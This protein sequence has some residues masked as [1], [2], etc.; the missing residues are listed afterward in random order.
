M[1]TKLLL[2]LTFTLFTIQMM[3]TNPIQKELDGISWDIE[4]T[5][6]PNPNS[7]VFQLN[8]QAD[9]P[10]TYEVKIVNL[11]GKTIVKKEVK[12][13]FETRFDLSTYPKGVYFMQIKSG[14]KQ[15]IKRVVIQ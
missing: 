8:I 10:T 2:L 7:G 1:K 12:T 9:I 5:V 6:Y 14:K 11:I 15:I 3:A 13:N 4:T